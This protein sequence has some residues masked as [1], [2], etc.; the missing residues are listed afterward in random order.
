MKKNVILCVDDE[1]IILDSIKTQLKESYGNSFFYETAENAIDALEII[2][3]LMQDAPKKLVVISDWLMPIIKGDEFLA[4][5]HEKYPKSLKIM[6]T[7]HASSE[8][9]EKTKKEADLY[10]CLKKPWSKS[11]LISTIDSGLL[12]T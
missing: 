3:E 5:V 12:L 6:L 11:E 9:I 1:K 4:E 7:G 10:K 2:E 8:S